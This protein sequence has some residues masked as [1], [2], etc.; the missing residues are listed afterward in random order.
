MEGHGERHLP[1]HSQCRYPE[2][3]HAG[4]Q[5]HRQDNIQ[6]EFLQGD[7]S[8]S[9]RRQDLGDQVLSSGGGGRDCQGRQGRLLDQGQ[10]GDEE[11]HAQVQAHGPRRGSRED[12]GGSCICLRVKSGWGAHT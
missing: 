11:L 8:D 4:P 10:D 6:R 9:A 7:D 1:H 12:A 2:A 3:A 5:H